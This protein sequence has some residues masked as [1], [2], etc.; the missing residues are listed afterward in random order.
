M[1]FADG[2]VLINETRK[3]AEGELERWRKALE[4][5][6]LKVRTTKT[7]YMCVNKGD[8]DGIDGQVKMQGRVVLEVEDFK[9]L[10][11]ITIYDGRS[12]GRSEEKDVDRME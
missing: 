12:D 9:Y 3:G 11:A 6:G 10:R 1:L 4:S 2:V 8:H 7:E 5:R